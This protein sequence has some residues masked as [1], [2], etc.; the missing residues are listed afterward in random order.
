MMIIRGADYEKRNTLVILT[1][2]FAEGEPACRQ[3][4]NLDNLDAMNTANLW[5]PTELMIEAFV[6]ILRIAQY[7]TQRPTCHSERSVAK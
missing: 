1:L 2:S 6:K 3:A 7:D 4:G 5:Q